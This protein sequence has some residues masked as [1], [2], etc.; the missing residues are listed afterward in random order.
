MWAI[1]QFKLLSFLCLLFTIYKTIYMLPSLFHNYVHE[2]KFTT[3]NPF[4]PR[5]L[6]CRTRILFMMSLN[7]HLYCLSMLLIF[8]FVYL[9]N[10]WIIENCPFVSGK[11]WFRCTLDYRLCHIHGIR[12]CGNGIFECA[13]GSCKSSE[14]LVYIVN[15]FLISVNSLAVQLI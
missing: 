4:V 5:V 9:L 13:Q 8:S 10:K 11:R 12:G 7:I 2:H 6:N 14:L 3:K 1:L 15:N